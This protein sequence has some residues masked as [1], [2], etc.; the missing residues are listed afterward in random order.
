MTKKKIQVAAIPDQSRL[1]INVGS[2]D[3]DINIE[4]GTRIQ[5]IEQGKE[6][7]DPSTHESLGE[8]SPV[9]ETL[10]ITNVLKKYSIARKI[11]KKSTAP[12]PISPML[13]VRKTT[14]YK[15]LNV[16]SSDNMNILLK[17]PVISIGDYVQLL[18]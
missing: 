4:E 5:V 17:N 12:F 6:I 13:A 16:K 7:F 9:K 2:S 10:I 8:Y 1:I 14:T 15:E 11:I 3:K 18:D